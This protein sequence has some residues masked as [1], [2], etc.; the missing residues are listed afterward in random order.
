MHT[1][2]L[3]YSTRP[4]MLPIYAGG[5]LVR[6]SGLAPKQALPS[7]RSEWKGFKF[8]THHYRRFMHACG[9]VP[10]DTMPLVYPLVFMFPLHLSI[11][12]H[13][14]FPLLY[15]RMMQIRNHVLQHRPI[16]LQETV[17]ISA[18]IV[19]Q[20]VVA[21]GL[22]MDMYSVLHAIDGPV[23][24]S[25]HTYYFPGNFGEPDRVSSLAQLPA[26]SEPSEATTWTMPRGGGFCFGLMA[27]DYN[28]IHYLAPY[29]RRMGYE[30]AFAHSQLS[31]ALCVRHL[32]AFAQD[33]PVRLD[34]A[35][36]GPVYYGSKVSMK[37]EEQGRGHRFDLYCEDNP[38]PCISGFLDSA[39]PDLEDIRNTYALLGC[40]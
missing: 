9:L 36:K 8:D 38:R 40:H 14:K 7:M 3:Q 24:E 39:E 5:L 6:R 19:G 34:V 35:I 23:W 11:V 30:R 22:E 18:E 15:V 37:H 33:T 21:K 20:R 10:S 4:R 31:L 26:L 13:R 27:G 28:A 32:P 29:A 1:V 12:G 25:I 17:D 2:R 16:D